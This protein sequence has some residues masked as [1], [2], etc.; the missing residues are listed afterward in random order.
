MDITS[1]NN[2]KIKEI[3]K[4]YKEK[5]FRDDLNLFIV[6]GYHMVLEAYKANLL[7]EVYSV[8]PVNF[9]FKDVFIVSEQILEKISKTVTPQGIIG[10]CKKIDKHEITDRVLML[11][12]IQDPGNLGTIL[13][14]ALAFNFKTVILDNCCDIYND[15]VLRST[16]GAIFNLNLINGDLKEYIIKLKDYDI[17]GTSLKNSTNLKDM[18]FLNKNIALILGNEGN[19]MREELLKMTKNNIF[20]EIENIESLNVAIAGAII[21]HWLKK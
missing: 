19:G 8:K 11:D 9:D 7:V 3:I 15:K 1:I 14:S 6:E 2:P 18:K 20:I 13:R 17:Y 4:I 10:L 5:K 16:Q 21:M 12:N